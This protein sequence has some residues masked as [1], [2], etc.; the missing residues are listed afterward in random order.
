VA[1]PLADVA[2]PGI[3]VTLDGAVIVVSVEGGRST[4]LD[5]QQ[6]FVFTDSPDGIAAAVEWVLDQI[7]DDFAEET[8]NPW[9]GP[10]PCSS[11]RR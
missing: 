10:L 4:I 1:R 3:S 8:T 5:L 7:Q 2:P 11:C 6:P 9:P